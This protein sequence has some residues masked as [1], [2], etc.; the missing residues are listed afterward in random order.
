[1]VVPF[2]TN[3]AAR[4]RARAPFATVALIALVTATACREEP[5]PVLGQAPSFALTDQTGATLRDQDLAGQ[6]AVVD[7]IF[8]RCTESCP[9]LTTRMSNLQRAIAQESEKRGKALPVRF[10]SI[11]LDP[12]HDTPAE[13][14]AYAT[15][16]KADT[17]S[18]S[19]LTGDPL[20][21]QRL[22]V[23]GFRV[24]VTRVERPGEAPDIQHGNWFVVVDKNAKVRGYYR[25]D[26]PEEMNKIKEDVIRLALASEGASG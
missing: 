12:E 21:V 26:T 24:G 23:S 7:F 3:T 18:W 8:L 1:M 22:A 16:W 19:F 2:H 10:V 20:E 4:V 15:K 11:S 17:K 5:L 25:T 14:Q 6:V 13:L 9:M